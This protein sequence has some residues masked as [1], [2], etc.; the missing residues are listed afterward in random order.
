[1]VTRL[2]R[3]SPGNLTPAN[4]LILFYAAAILAGSLA[5]AT[6]WAAQPTLP[7][8]DALFTATSAQCVTGLVVVDTG[9][10]FTL[11]GQGVILALIQLGGIGITTFSVYLF[12]YLRSGVG[13]RDRWIL[14]ETLMHTPVRSLHELVRDV[15]HLTLII[16]AIGAALLAVVFVPQFGWANGLYQAVFHSISAFCNAGFSLF[17]DSL[18]S[19][20]AHPLVNTVIM[21]LITLG[22]IGFLVIRELLDRARQKHGRKRRLSLHTKLVLVT[23]LVLTVGG[24]IGIFWLEGASAYQ[25]AP[26]TERFWG[27]LFQSVSARTAGFNSVDLNTFEV[28]TLLLMMFLMFVGASPGSTGG[29]IKTTSLALFVA[30]LYSRLKGLRTINIFKRTLPEETATKTMTLVMLALFWLGIMVFFLLCVQLPG[31]S[32][33]ESRG[34]FLD[35]TFEVI[36]AFA[37]VGL[38]LGATAKLG[39]WGKIIVI[40]LMFVGRIGLLS[41]AFAVVRRKRGD[42]AEYAQENIMIG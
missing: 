32:F 6:P 10:R 41:F 12:V 25:A 36:S 34:A 42:S 29:G 8:L 3:F 35:Y 15:I 2:Q 38:S 27:A 7:F 14:N 30:M 1:M 23:S 4:A 16:E 26:L 20:R 39:G 11:F 5:L 28:P 37:T 24:A 9:T 19:Y 33:I 13:L 22:G 40:L 18:I 21:S 31:L 17:P